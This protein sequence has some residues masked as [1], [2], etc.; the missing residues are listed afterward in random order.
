MVRE[1]CGPEH[2][3]YTEHRIY[4]IIELYLLLDG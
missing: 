3:I 4:R 1:P 2:R